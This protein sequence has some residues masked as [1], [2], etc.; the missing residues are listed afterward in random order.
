MIPD[1]SDYRPASES[2]ESDFADY[3][4]AQE[5]WKTTQQYAK[6]NPLPVILLTLLIG[7]ILGALLSPRK[8]KQ[9][10]AVQAAKELLEA[11]Y[12]Q[13]AEVIPQ[14]SRVKFSK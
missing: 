5:T 7:V 1:P 14:L 10:D 2:S 9:K 11:A 13:L 12:E 6:E 3:N 8:R 4:K